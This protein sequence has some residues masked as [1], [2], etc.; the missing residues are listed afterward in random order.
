[1]S[2]IKNLKKAADRI[3]KAIQK[4]E[5]IILYGDADLDGT[6][7][8]IILKEAIKSLGG[9]IS[10]FYFP[11][12]E[13]EGYGLT[14][15]GLDFLKGEAPALLIV[16]DCGIGNLKEV[17]LAKK[18]GF[19]VVI[20]DHHETL[21]KL[22][23]AEIIV[24]PKQ[25]SDKYPFK[26]LACAGIAFKVSEAVLGKKMTESLRRNFLE[27]TAIATVA[28]MMPK[29][30]ENKI[31][32]EQGLSFLESSWRPGI[33]AFLEVFKDYSDLNQKVSKIISILN[34]RDVK[35][36][37][38][39]SFRLLTCPSSE[40]AEQIVRE[41][42][43]KDVMRKDRME[44]MMAEV[45]KRLAEKEEPVIFEGDPDFE[46]TLVSSVASVLCR[47]YL[48]PVFIYKKMEKESQGTVRTPK[49]VNGVSLMKNCSGL[50]LTFG[51][52]AQAAGFRI[53]NENLEKFKDC[54]MKNI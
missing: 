39:A 45:E 2:E 37:L 33:K 22:P 54:L 6:S 24:D 9:N 47:K 42:M 52:H 36:N 7:S 23:S 26:K 4:K 11:D 20:I 35:E 30:S 1:M 16:L 53:E 38:P 43:E 8:V 19:K 51:G 18:L 32:I 48:K 40:K 49:E 46:L 44:E 41:L 15:K 12:R 28:D 27:M 25:K 5:N 14:E 50:L 13:K 21:D 17:K 34:I 31:F 3:L 29:E 10:A